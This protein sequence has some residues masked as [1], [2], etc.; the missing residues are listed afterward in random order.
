MS[1]RRLI[2]NSIL[3]KGLQNLFAFMPVGGGHKMCGVQ[4]RKGYENSILYTIDV[5][6]LNICFAYTLPTVVPSHSKCQPHLLTISQYFAD[7]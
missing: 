3:L 6:A 1:Y 4:Q 7:L 2:V 5:W